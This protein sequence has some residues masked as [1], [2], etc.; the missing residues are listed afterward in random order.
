[1]GLVGNQG[2]PRVDALGHRALPLRREASAAPRGLRSRPLHGVIFTSFRDFLTDAYGDDLTRELFA[3]EPIYLLSEAY[4][5]ER[6]L[7]LVSRTAGATGRSADEVE[8]DFGVFTGETTFTR[9]YPAFFAIAPTAR[10][11]L[12]TVESRIHELVRATI[13][14]A[15][16][17]RLAITELDDDGVSIDYSSPRRLCM[18][19]RGLVEG[20]ARHYGETATIDELAC[21]REGAPSCRFEVRLSRSSPAA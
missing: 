9:L 10:E 6:L 18:L 8:H 17:P 2:F 3:Q 4:P 1:M 16:P 7:D 11:F 21:M 12:L 19:L 5:D 15:V 13:P 20:T 14:H